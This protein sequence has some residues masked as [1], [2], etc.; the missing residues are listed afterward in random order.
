MVARGFLC[1]RIV[2][3]VRN[4]EP[5]ISRLVVGKIESDEEWDE[6]L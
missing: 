5:D 3:N 1:A 4:V 2:F 6:R